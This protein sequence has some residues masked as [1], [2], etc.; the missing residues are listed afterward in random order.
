MINYNTGQISPLAIHHIGRALEGEDLRLMDATVPLRE[1]PYLEQLVFHYLLSKFK[2]PSFYNFKQGDE[3]SPVMELVAQIFNDKAALLPVSKDLA[4]MLY[5][6]QE[7]PSIKTGVLAVCHF[8]DI[9][10]EDELLEAVGIFKI[11]SKAAFLQLDEM[12]NAYKFTALEGLA[13]NGLDKGCLILNTE[14]ADG[15]K[16]CVLD[17]TA[18]Q[19]A[20][21]W[22]DSFL[23]LVERKDAYHNTTHYIN[24]TNDFVNERQKS[25]PNP[26]GMEKLEVMEASEKYFN[27]NESFNEEEYMGALFPDER[28]AEDFQNYKNQVS[29]KRGFDLGEEFDISD[30]AVKKKSK[31]FKSVIKLDTNFH[32]YVH[33][34]RNKIERGED[35]FGRKFYKVFYEEEH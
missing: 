7:H 35:E 29:S 2:E 12:Q 28:V 11:E 16:V 14:K 32:I 21:F 9:L 18:V 1:E 4:T 27:S 19:E 31:V 5:K 33:G 6:G 10:V 24:L 13:M 22:K 23:Q 15:Y 25:S 34:D 20:R 17:K 26:D 30:A 3:P 8:E